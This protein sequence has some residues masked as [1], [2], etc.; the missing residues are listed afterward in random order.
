MSYIQ[1]IVDKFGGVTRCAE[2]LNTS[3]AT[4]SNWIRRKKISDAGK[5][6]L[7]QAAGDAGIPVTWEQLHGLTQGGTEKQDNAT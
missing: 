6:A 7:Y 4:V 1:D 2:A 5:V 3:K